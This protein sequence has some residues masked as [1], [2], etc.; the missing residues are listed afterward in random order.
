MIEALKD[1]GCEVILG[2]AEAFSLFG[3]I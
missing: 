2:K 3:G 1:S